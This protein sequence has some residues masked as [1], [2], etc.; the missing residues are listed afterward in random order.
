MIHPMIAVC[1]TVLVL[2]A[3]FLLIYR[4]FALIERDRESARDKEV[5]DHDRG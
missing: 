1:I 5:A 3:G 2:L 4:V